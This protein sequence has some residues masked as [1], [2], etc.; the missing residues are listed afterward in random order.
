MLRLHVASTTNAITLVGDHMKS[1]LLPKG[2]MSE[3]RQSNNDSNAPANITR[4]LIRY[5][6]EFAT[7]YS[8]IYCRRPGVM[9]DVACDWLTSWF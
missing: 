3:L 5:R 8:V 4:H 1:D 7:V 2:I 6:Q 9:R